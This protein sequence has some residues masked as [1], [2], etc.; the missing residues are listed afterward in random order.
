MNSLI[1]ICGLSTPET[2]DAALD[3]VVVR[4]DDS[5]LLD[6][7]DELDETLVG[8]RPH[9]ILIHRSASDY[10]FPQR[11]RV[12]TEGIVQKACRLEPVCNFSAGSHVFCRRGMI[13]PL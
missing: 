13:V 11:R 5:E 7:V 12:V 8:N 4:L 1:K 10:R 3:A 2:L 6:S 9:E